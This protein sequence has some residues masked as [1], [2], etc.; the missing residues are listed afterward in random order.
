MKRNEIIILGCGSSLGVPRIDG[1]WG[2]VDKKNSKNIR[3]RCSLFIKY[4]S[5]N[6]LIDTSPDIKNQLLYNKINKIDYILYTHDHG[7]QTHGINELRP[8]AWKNKSRINIYGDKN[9]LKSLTKSFE[10]LFKK[11]DKFYKAILKKNLI[12]KK[13][14]LKKNKDKIIFKPIKVQHGNIKALGFL[15]N[16]I[17]YISDCSHIDTKELLKLKNLDLLILDCLKYKKHKTHLNFKESIYYIDKLKPKKTILTN[18]HSDMDYKSLKNKLK[19]KK[20]IFPAYD[21]M[22]ISYE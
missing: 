1:Y 19:N 9:T 15:F 13:I 17:A 12:N 4:K 3:T 20:N 22:K 14:I 10:Y 18:L 21:G 5:L 11:K 16:K 6:V 8:L 7:D 2:R